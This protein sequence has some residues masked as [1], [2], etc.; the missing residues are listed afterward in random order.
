MEGGDITLSKSIDKRI[1]E[2]VFD[3]KEFDSNISQSMSVLERFDQKLSSFGGEASSN[4]QVHVSALDSMWMGFFQ[5]VGGRLEEF[6]HSILEKLTAPL[7]ALK[8]KINSTVEDLT[9]SQMSAGWNKYEEMANNTQAILSATRESYTQLFESMGQ[10]YNEAEHLELVNEQMD[11]LLWYTDETSYDFTD[12]ASNVGK[13]TSAG[14]EL[15][16]AVNA[17]MG[18]ANWGSAA[19]KSAQ[20]VARAMYNISQA[21]GSGAMLRTDWKSIEMLNMNTPEMKQ[22]LANYGVLEGTLQEIGDGIYE[23]LAGEQYNLN[24]LFADGLKDRWM[25]ADVMMGAFDMYGQFSSQLADF[26]TALEDT[27][28]KGLDLVTQQ[29]ELI[30][31]WKKGKEGIEGEGIQLQDLI[32]IYGMTSE[33][34]EEMAEWLDLLSDEQYELGERAFKAGQEYKTFTDVLSATRDAASSKWMK[35]WQTI[36]G[37]LLT[38]KELWSEMGESFYEFFVTPVENLQGVIEEWAELGGQ[39]DLFEGI[40]NSLEAILNIASA[41]GEVLYEVFLQPIFGDGAEGLLAFTSGFKAFSERLLE[42]SENLEWL[43]GILRGFIAIIRVPLA[44]ASSILGLI[45]KSRDGMMSLGGSIL[46]T[47]GNF[48]NFLDRI[49]PRKSDFDKFFQ[50]IINGFTKLKNLFNSFLEA[51]FGTNL[52]K[53][54]DSVRT[55]LSK[56]I[57]I[58]G[59][60]FQKSMED[61]DETTETVGGRIA[62]RFSIL[63]KVFGFVG[64]IFQKVCNLISMVA[65]YIKT[66]VTKIG[67]GIGQFVDAIASA[68]STGDFD[69]VFDIVNGGILA[70]IGASIIKFITGF[71]SIGK[72]AGGI[73]KNLSEIFENVGGVFEGWQKKLNAEALMNIAKAIAIIAASL[74]VLSLVDSKKLA[75]ALTGL[76][77]AFGELAGFMTIM[78]RQNSSTTLKGALTNFI[79]AKSAD[80]TATAMIKVAAA[81]LILSIA[82]GSLASLSWGELVKGLV[83]VGL[84]L[85]AVVFTLKSMPKNAGKGA[86]SMVILAVAVNILAKAVGY[87]GA[88]SWR[89]LVKGLGSVVVLIAAM[90]A[91]VKL[92]PKNAAK[93]AGSMIIMA[94]AVAILATSVEAFSKLSIRQLVKGLGSVVVLVGALVAAVKLMP[95]DSVHGATSMI[96]MGAALA[97]I[98]QVVQQFAKL[99]VPELAKGLISTAVA[100]GLL[101]TAVKLMPKDSFG[102]AVSMVLLGAALAIVAQVVQ[103]FASMSIPELAKGLISLAAALTAM[104]LAMNFA[105]GSIAGALALVIMAGAIAILVPS[106]R[107]LGEMSVGEIV[108]SLIA[109]AAVL[110]IIGVAGLLLAPVVPVIALLGLALLALGVGVAAAGVGLL[111][112]AAGLSALVALGS[113]GIMILCE[114]IKALV[115]LFPEIAIGIAEAFAQFIITIGNYAGPVA[116]AFGNILSAVLGIVKEYA[117]E[118]VETVLTVLDELLKSLADHVPSFVD[119]GLKII[120]GFLEGIKENIGEVVTTFIDIIL[121]TIQA[122]EEKIPD[123]VQEGWNL[124]LAII[125]GIADGIEDNTEALKEAMERLAKAMLDFVK[126]FLGI[127]SPSQVFH[128]EV[129]VNIVEGIKEGINAVKDKISGALESA[130]EGAK[131]AA[132]TI[133][134]TFSDIGNAMVEGVKNGVEWAKGILHSV[135]A[136][137]ANAVKG[138]ATDE[139]QI[140]SPSKVF[141]WIGEMMDE[142]LAI[143]LTDNVDSVI[144]ASDDVANASMKALQDAMSHVGD[145]VDDDMTMTP[146]IRPVV[147]L[148]EIETGS[149]AMNKMLNSGMYTA[150]VGNIGIGEVSANSSLLN[151]INS[152]SSAQNPY[153]GINIYVTGGDNANASDIADEVMRRLDREVQRRKV[154]FG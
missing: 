63:A 9:V 122:I 121:E 78:N 8:N 53:I 26:G 49:L 62:E 80:K 98:A 73:L 21:M 141:M 11:K 144:D 90:V 137:I 99:S 12:M 3:N 55:A 66:L 54:F 23:T 68:F 31:G 71:G 57:E 38:A 46:T 28:A 13:F 112:V 32:D 20:E 83:A 106:L 67:E 132:K 52:G 18:I 88:L 74:V 96:L 110:A 131:S 43:K 77:V 140:H 113:A 15:E 139:A 93:G 135:G 25:D 148:S 37:D 147:D 34:A 95:K 39:E 61:A 36:F 130:L 86:T 151:A 33:E 45:F 107:A 115:M 108:K 35:I 123:I 4:M 119:S 87:L 81:V 91:A 97:I 6:A 24:Q 145:A 102:G 103:Q 100:L 50:T 51:G 17:M 127:R 94:A 27:H 124:V 117:P 116:E 64:K 143:G 10:S 84:L 82:V 44:L 154:A 114:A 40:S 120:I 118:I 134:G 72:N 7:D 133:A 59:K 109:L 149:N 75:S 146:V 14:V 30:D 129:G 41:I 42:A 128:D 48:G 142:G 153:S 65:P 56:L 150:G 22:L 138:G 58:L 69:K 125:N 104:I 92:M 89:S 16:D 105:N 47:A 79:D 85:A 19:G 76:T 101:V 111:A 60:P 29:L 1:V 5:N 2:M 126:T 152:M 70:G 136:S